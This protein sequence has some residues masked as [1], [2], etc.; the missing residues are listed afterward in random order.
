MLYLTCTTRTSVDL[1]H[2][3]VSRAKDYVSVDVVQH[4]IMS[5]KFSK[6]PYLFGYKAGVYPFKTATNTVELEWL[7]Q[8]WDHENLFQ[9]K[10]VPAKQSKPFIFINGTIG[11]EVL[12]MGFYS[13]NFHAVIFIFYF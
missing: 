10:I 1:A 5:M 4:K 13:Q 6:L 8:A 11:T 3:G 12:Y 7:K 2:Y 9:S